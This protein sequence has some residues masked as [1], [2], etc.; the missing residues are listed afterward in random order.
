MSS[1]QVKNLSVSYDR[2][3]D[4]LKEITMDFKESNCVGVLGA[5]GSGKSTLFR[6]IVGLLKPSQGEVYYD[7]R[8][9]KYNKKA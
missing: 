9:L 2:K 1:L 4:I 3:N 7:N 6:S 8:L 5:N